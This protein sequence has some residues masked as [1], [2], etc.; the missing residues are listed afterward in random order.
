VKTSLGHVGLNL[1]SAGE[2][3]AFWKDLLAFLDFT[4]ELEEDGHFDASDGH[5]SLC[6]TVTRPDYLES[7]YHRRRTG[8][9]HIAFQV[10]SAVLVDAFT[11]GFLR[12]RGIP[13]LYG[14][15]RAYPEYGPGCY[16]VFFE[17]P[18]RIKIE[19]YAAG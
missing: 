6:V 5:A 18:D 11:R 4:I 15:P 2:P 14:G 10:G 7:A 13:R 19:V 3:F 8:L 12:R 16:S 9:N 1:S 17:D